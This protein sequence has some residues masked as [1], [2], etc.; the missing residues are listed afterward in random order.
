MVPPAAPMH[1]RTSEGTGQG[2]RGA[3]GVHV[4]PNEQ[5]VVLPSAT[6]EAIVLCIVVNHL[7]SLLLEHS[8]V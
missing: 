4:D 5:L 6:E 1:L 8:C 7:L 2:E 3:S